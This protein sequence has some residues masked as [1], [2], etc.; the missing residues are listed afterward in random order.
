MSCFDRKRT[1]TAFLGSSQTLRGQRPAVICACCCNGCTRIGMVIVGTGFTPSA[2]LGHGVKFRPL[3][4]VP[5]NQVIRSHP[6]GKEVLQNPFGYRG[7]NFPPTVS[8]R[9]SKVLIAS[10]LHG[11]FG[12]V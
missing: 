9:P 6:S 2:F 7:L 3:M 5:L 11:S 12:R 10:L 1:V 4:N 8:R